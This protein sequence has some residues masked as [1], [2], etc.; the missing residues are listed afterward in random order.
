MGASE[1]PADGVLGLGFPSLSHFHG[2]SPLF[3]TLFNEGKLSQP[4]FSLQFTSSG[5]ELYV[6]GMNEALYIHSTLVFI[7]VTNPALVSANT[8]RYG[9]IL[10]LLFRVSGR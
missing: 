7:P 2:Q 4:V 3:H 1:F 8:R 5:G 6:G 10:R 9:R